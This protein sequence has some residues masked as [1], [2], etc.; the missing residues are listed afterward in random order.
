[1]QFFEIRKAA[2]ISRFSYKS[3][4]CFIFW[5]LFLPAGNLFV[6][7]QLVVII[8]LIISMKKK[9]VG[10]GLGEL[11]AEIMEVI[12]RLKSALVR[13]IWLKISKKRKIA[14]T[15]V[16]TVMSRLFNKGILKRRLNPAGAYIY[17][18][19]WGKEK[20]FALSSK[21][22]INNLLHQFG[23]IA[24]VQFIDILEIKNFK[25]LKHWQKKLKKLS[26]KN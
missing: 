14:Y 10:L 11:E 22:V 3:F 6:I 15:T 23:D 1:M 5:L 16:M 17:T 21:R 18:P 20:F 4:Y 24:V 13:E 2:K 25:D 8:L 7:L 9:N 19:V 26:I 12:W